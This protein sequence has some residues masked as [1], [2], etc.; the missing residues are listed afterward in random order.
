M[1]VSLGA[2]GISTCTHGLWRG[3]G[4]NQNANQCLPVSV[5]L[6]P[7][8]PTDTDDWVLPERVSSLFNLLSASALKSLHGLP[9][10]KTVA[11]HT[12]RRKT[13]GTWYADTD[14]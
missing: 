10:D 1:S 2:D 4:S 5:S 7:V 8:S 13:P 3:S 14:T 12:I 11:G 9:T 6:I